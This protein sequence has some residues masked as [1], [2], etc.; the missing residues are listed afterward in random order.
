[1]NVTED[2]ATAKMWEEHITL[3]GC[4]QVGWPLLSWPL[5]LC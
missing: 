2:Q 1:M 4:V 3:S 5:L